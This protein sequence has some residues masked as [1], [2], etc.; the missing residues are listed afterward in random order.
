MREN[1]RA[2]DCFPTALRFNG[3]P[4]AFSPPPTALGWALPNKQQEVKQNF[5][6]L[7]TNTLRALRIGVNSYLSTFSPTAKPQ[8]QKSLKYMAI[9]TLLQYK[10]PFPA[11]KNALSGILNFGLKLAGTNR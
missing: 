11:N 10:K 3:T 1:S 6:I 2:G 5:F 9:G 7:C 8:K 4:L